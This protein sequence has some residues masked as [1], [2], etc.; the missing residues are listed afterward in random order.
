MIGKLI[1]YLLMFITT[2]F[3]MLAWLLVS[4][5]SIAIGVMLILISLVGWNKKE[6]DGE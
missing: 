5:C 3:Q 6:E 2:L 4:L 1:F